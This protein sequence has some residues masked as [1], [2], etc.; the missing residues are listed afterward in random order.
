MTAR[1]P[2]FDARLRLLLV[3]VSVFFLTLPSSV[4]ASGADV[5]GA[6]PSPFP[7]AGEWQSAEEVALTRV[8]GVKAQMCNARR[9]REWLRVRCGG[10]KASAITLLGG[11]ARGL[12]YDIEP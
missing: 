5:W 9:V 2:S 1:R 4:P 12:R 7:K 11:E 10:F 3:T 8:A 6:A